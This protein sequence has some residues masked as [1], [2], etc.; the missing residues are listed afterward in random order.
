M[1]L[2]RN[3]NSNYTRLRRFDFCKRHSWAGGLTEFNDGINQEST[4]EEGNAYYS[5]AL[6]G[7]KMLNLQPLRR[8]L[9][10][11]KFLHLKCGGNKYEKMFTNNKVT[12]V[13]VLLILCCQVCEGTCGVEITCFKKRWC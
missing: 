10:H 12:S 5:A 13:S 11:W 6:I 9:H 2:S 8:H 4:H 3:S 1:S 7:M